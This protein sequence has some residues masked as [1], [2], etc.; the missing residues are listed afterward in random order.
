MVHQP[1][2]VFFLR[3]HVREE[4]VTVQIVCQV[5]QILHIVP[6]LSVAESGGEFRRF[7]RR[8]LCDP[9]CEVVQ[10]VNG[11]KLSQLSGEALDAGGVFQDDDFLVPQA[12][13]ADLP[14]NG[15]YLFRGGGEGQPRGG[16]D[17]GVVF[18]Q[19]GDIGGKLHAV[20]GSHRSF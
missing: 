13:H 18:A 19:V 14:Q 8:Q 11:D 15:L 5:D 12:V 3:P 16:E 2:P 9:A 10:F 1:A 20:I 7:L 17:P 4:V 6:V